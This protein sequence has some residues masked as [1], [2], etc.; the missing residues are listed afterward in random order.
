MNSGAFLNYTV[1]LSQ[2]LRDEDQ[3]EARQ[4]IVGALL[5]AR[6]YKVQALATGFAAHLYSCCFMSWVRANDNGIFNDS[7]MFLGHLLCGPL[8][9]AKLSTINLPR[10]NLRRQGLGYGSPLKALCPGI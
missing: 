1:F 6:E 2:S 7:M 8:K 9:P 5:G 4:T 10:K 3:G